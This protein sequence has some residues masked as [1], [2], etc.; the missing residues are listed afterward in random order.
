MLLS[1]VTLMHTRAELFW[2]FLRRRLNRNAANDVPEKANKG[3]TN[4]NEPKELF[5]GENDDF[6]SEEQRREYLERMK[7]SREE[8]AKKLDFVLNRSGL[9]TRMQVWMIFRE[10]K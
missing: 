1:E 10:K 4:Q 5:E 2:R 3:E 8:R 9:N 7:R 6:E